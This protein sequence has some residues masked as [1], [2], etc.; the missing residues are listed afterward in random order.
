MTSRLLLL[1]A[2]A[3]SGKTSLSRAL[4]QRGWLRISLDDSLR[5]RGLE[6]GQGLSEEAWNEASLAACTS[7]AEAGRQGQD[8]V[9]DET[10]CFRFLRD[11]YRDI[12]AKAG[13]SARLVVLKLPIEELRARVSA[14]R[15]SLQRQDIA[16]AVLEEHLAAFEWPSADEPHVLLDASASLEQQLASLGE[17][18]RERAEPD[19]PA[20]AGA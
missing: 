4:A 12:A 17:W 15:R 3:F 18:A 2:P 8:V 20:R 11:R 9:L 5:A 6:P 16:D 14:N 19:A 10:L 1:C 13:M 7:L